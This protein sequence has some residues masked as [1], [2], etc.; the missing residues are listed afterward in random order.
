MSR[1]A[2]AAG[3]SCRIVGWLLV[4]LCA[5]PAAAEAGQVERLTITTASGGRFPFLVEIA[6]TAPKRARGLMFRQRMAPEEGMLFLFDAPEVASFWMKNT[7]L[8]LDLF[9]IGPEGRILDMHQ[10]AVPYSTRPMNSAMPVVAVLELLAGTAARL[11]IR[12]GDKVEHRAF[13][14]GG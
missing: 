12:A 2:S 14:G 6:D 7:P 8:A 10:R 11:G 4:F 3:G 5:L 1:A 13:R 9:F